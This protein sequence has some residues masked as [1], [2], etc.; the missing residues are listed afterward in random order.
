MKEAILIKNKLDILLIKYSTLFI[1]NIVFTE[2][3]I[4]EKAAIK[5]FSVSTQT[6]HI[7]LLDFRSSFLVHTVHKDE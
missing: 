2:D 7:I 5:V 4:E 1:R 3:D 6:V